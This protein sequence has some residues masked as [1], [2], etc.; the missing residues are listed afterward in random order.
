MYKRR[1]RKKGKREEGK[2]TIFP[3]FPSVPHP[4]NSVIGSNRLLS[5]SCRFEEVDMRSLMGRGGK[6]L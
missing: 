3:P 6:G 1:W 2:R 4:W 5:Q